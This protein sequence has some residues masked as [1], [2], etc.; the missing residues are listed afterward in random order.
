MKF[1]SKLTKK[2]NKLSKEDRLEYYIRF[3][4]FPRLNIDVRTISFLISTI[5]LLFM[6]LY[7]QWVQIG[8]VIPELEEQIFNTFDLTFLFLKVLFISLFV[9]V[10]LYVWSVLIFLRQRKEFFEENTKYIR[11]N[12]GF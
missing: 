10:G 8:E 7:V 9:D 5:C 1:E 12:L 4:D 3:K 2:I 6:V 11:E